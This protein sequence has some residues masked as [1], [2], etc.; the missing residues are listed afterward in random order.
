MK[1]AN[2]EIKL[3]IKN[4]KN[5]NK[6]GCEFIQLPKRDMHYKIFYCV[7]LRHKLVRLLLPE[8]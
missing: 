8:T 1:I 3:L 4:S 7:N 2:I 6:I 5:K